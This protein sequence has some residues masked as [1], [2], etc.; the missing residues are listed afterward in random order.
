MSLPIFTFRDHRAEGSCSLGAWAAL[1]RV[2][3]LRCFLA[4]GASN[5]STSMLE[6]LS[7]GELETEEL[8]DQ[9]KAELE[10]HN[11]V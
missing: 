2:S 6:Q 1:S 5:L 8:E 3:L 4:Q 11:E 10:E 7:E 9:I